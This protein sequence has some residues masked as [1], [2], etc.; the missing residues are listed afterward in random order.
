MTKK[1]TA[2]CGLDCKQCGAYLALKNNDEELRIKT[3]QEWSAQFGHDFVP[4][5]INC[6]GCC[7]KEGR[8]GGYCQACPLRFCAFSKNVSN[9]YA[10]TEFHDCQTLKDFEA[11]SG[12]DVEKKFV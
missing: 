9:C 10:C 2:V 7:I 4:K 3:A 6:V 12:I 5:D 8:H 1:L 11:H